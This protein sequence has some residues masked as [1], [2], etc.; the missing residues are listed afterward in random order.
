[1]N[2]LLVGGEA[3]GLQ[4]LKVV[5]RGGHRVPAVLASSAEPDF[6][7]AT[8]S[9]RAE[10]IGVPMWPASLVKEPAFAATL[11]REAV[12][13]ILNVHSLYVIRHEILAVPRIGAFNLHPGP[14]PGYAGLNS[15]SWAIYRRGES[16]HAVTLHWMVPEIDAGPIAYQ[17]TFDIEETETGLSLALKCVRAGIPLVDRLLRVA[18]DDPLRIP[19]IEQE[20]T[21]RAYFG[22]QPPHQGR[23]S[24]S[25][26]ARAIHD[27][28]RA[29]D[30]RPLRSPWG[31]PRTLAGH[32]EIEI[33]SVRRTGRPTDQPPG[34]TG[35]ITED[36]LLVASG[37]EWVVVTEVMEAGRYCPAAAVLTGIARLGHP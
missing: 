20:R 19:R 25:E 31:H 33:V 7:G 36:G 4:A 27:F 11:C 22:R 24:W 26:P 5:T 34:T 28:V 3:A 8:L 2:I 16:A 35:S 21:G 6:G 10:R 30:Y 15:S 14:L 29:S 1:M 32:R 13:I 12:D 37:D 17:Q 23:L 18:A 9:R